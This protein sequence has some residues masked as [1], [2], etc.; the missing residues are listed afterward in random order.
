MILA[1]LAV[2]EPFSFKAIVDEIMLQTG[3]EPLR[4]DDFTIYDALGQG[5]LIYGKV[6][7]DQDAPKFSN[8]TLK[9]IKERT[10]LPEDKRREIVFLNDDGIP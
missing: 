3:V 9:Y 2:N 5:H 8:Y 6:K 10:D 4:Q 1:D 7:E